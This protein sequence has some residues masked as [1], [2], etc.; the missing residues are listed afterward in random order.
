MM[1]YPTSVWT[2]KAT[3]NVTSAAIPHTFA[4]LGFDF[5]ST[6]KTTKPTMGKQMERISKAMLI[7]S[8]SLLA[9]SFA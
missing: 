6:K 3:I 2:A 5:L 8:L 7:S 4:V 1:D 9:L